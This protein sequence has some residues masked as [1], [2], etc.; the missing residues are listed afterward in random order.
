MKGAKI[1]HN[2]RNNLYK[3]ELN[4][5][6]GEVLSLKHALEAYAEISPVGSDVNSYLQYEIRNFDEFKET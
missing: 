2:K 4:L 3:V 5:T 1:T 6:Q